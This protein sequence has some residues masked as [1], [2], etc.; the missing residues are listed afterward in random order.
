MST[1]AD[2]A[3][4]EA[5]EQHAD[6]S[7]FRRKFERDIENFFSRFPFLL[8]GMRDQR[9]GTARQSLFSYLI[10]GSLCSCSR[11]AHKSPNRTQRKSRRKNLTT[12]RFASLYVLR[13]FNINSSFL[14]F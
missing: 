11:A 4:G 3:G 2:S 9:D 13:R 7:F 8:S 1:T 14:T 12:A 6:R 10:W 5:E